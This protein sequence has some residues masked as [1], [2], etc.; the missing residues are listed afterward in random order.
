MDYTLILL[1]LLH[2]V[3]AFAWIGVG[4]SISVFI[5]P[6]AMI[7]GENGMRFLRT[8]LTHGVYARIF[9]ISSGLTVLAGILLYVVGDARLHFSDN[10]NMVLG[11]GALTGI[12]AGIHGGAFTGRAMRAL[13]ATLVDKIPDTDRAIGAD[14]LV[15]LREQAARAVSHGRVST[16]LSVIALLGMASARYL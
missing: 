12:V 8:L 2:I 4:A 14:D 16:V 7:M 6:S 1:R 5:L 15:I 3:A 11:L 10:G 13:G 9:P